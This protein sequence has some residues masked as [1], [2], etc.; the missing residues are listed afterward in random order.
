[1]KDLIKIL[2]AYVLCWVALLVPVPLLWIA[3]L[4]TFWHTDA[5]WWAVLTAVVGTIPMFVIGA[6]TS[7]KMSGWFLRR[8]DKKLDDQE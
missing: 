1:M 7:F 4:K 3:L 8:F 2:F 6:T 5:I